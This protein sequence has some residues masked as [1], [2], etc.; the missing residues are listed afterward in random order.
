MAMFMTADSTYFFRKENMLG[1]SMAAIFRPVELAHD[2][3]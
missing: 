3:G 1:H 2:E